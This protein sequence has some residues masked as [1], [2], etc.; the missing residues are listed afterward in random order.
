MKILK[1]SF[2][3]LLA[4]LA[5]SLSAARFLIFYINDNPSFV[6]NII[7]KKTPINIQIKKINSNWVGVFPSAKAEITFYDKK[8]QLNYVGSVQLQIN[9][10]KSIIF[11]K[12][13]IKSVYADN[14]KYTGNIT[15]LIYEYT[16]R[17]KTD[18]IIV[19]SI[20]IANSKF[21]IWHDKNKFEL[22][23][24]NI[25]ADKNNINISSNV[26]K[27]K[28]VII[29]I[30]DLEIKNNK[31]NK[32]NYKL[33]AQGDF[34]YNFQDFFTNR[35][36]KFSGRDLLIKINGTYK[37]NNFVNSKFSIKTTGKSSIYFDNSLFKDINLK[38]AFSGNIKNIFNL[39]ITE[40]SSKSKSNRIYRFNNVS[41]SYKNNKNIN[42]YANNIYIDTNKVFQDYSFLKKNNFNFSGN[43]KNLQVILFPN[44][45]SKKFFLS[46]NFSNSSFFSNKN[47]VKNFSG[48]ISIDNN[49]A[50]IKSNSS[51]IEI[52]YNSILSKK[53]GFD[54]ING[55]V[56]ISNLI[57]PDINIS[58]LKISNNQLDLSISGNINWKTDS[59]SIFT[60]LNYV[61]MRFVTDYLPKNFITKKSSEY[62]SKAFL[63]GQTNNGYVYIDGTLSKYPFYDDYSGISYAVFP[64]QDLKVDY[65]RGWIPFDDISGTAYFNKREAHFISNNFQVLDTEVSESSLY[66]KNVKSAELLLN[67]DLKGPLKDLLIYSNKAGLSKVKKIILIK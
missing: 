2:L 50:Y 20:A 51:N 63:K 53:L 33:E 31:L 8:S 61:D 6:Q 44:N 62:F 18:K 38:L 13:V 57:A 14:I 52:L 26:D 22:T 58:N 54:N 56:S 12:P 55:E 35:D 9:I 46:G 23:N 21:S 40:F 67:G 11:F 47:Y 37:N 59:V 10:Y 3:I 1:Y 66:I 49:K 15:N 34:N 29:A 43:I 39:E 65:K 32:V 36:V 7:S 24:T 27:D 41:I 17:K 5:I 60:S 30:K 28:K 16:K 42:I 4:Y 64:I 25:L 45:F 48:Y 19:E